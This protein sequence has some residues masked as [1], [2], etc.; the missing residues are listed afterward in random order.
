MGS[1]FY[2]SQGS[3][4]KCILRGEAT[5]PRQNFNNFDFCFEF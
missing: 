3:F 5:F 1:T 2:P 4:S